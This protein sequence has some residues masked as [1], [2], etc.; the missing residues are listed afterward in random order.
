MAIAGILHTTIAYK[1]QFGKNMIAALGEQCALR[2][3][4][5]AGCLASCIGFVDG[6]A[7]PIYRPTQHQRQAYNG[8]K[9][10]HVIKFQMAV[11]VNG[12]I[13]SVAGQLRGAATMSRLVAKWT[14]RAHTKELP[15]VRQF[16]DRAYP[17]K[18]WLLR[19]YKGNTLSRE[20]VEFN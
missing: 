10:V 3:D 15:G 13:V 12:L 8:H 19:P 4:E 6:T 5:Q 14:G 9:R 2:V 11:L 1:M 20:Q 17:V 7:R 18:R 16:D